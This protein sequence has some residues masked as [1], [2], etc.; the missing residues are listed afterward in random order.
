[1]PPV[2][3]TIILP[4][5]LPKQ[6]TS[7]GIVVALKSKAGSV[8]VTLRVTSG[9]VEAS[10]NLKAVSYTHLTLPTILLV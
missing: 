3:L 1:M 6:E 2:A 7:V 5:V 4:F 9:A 10:V 8:I